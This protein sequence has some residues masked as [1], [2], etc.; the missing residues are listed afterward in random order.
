[1]ETLERVIYNS[2]IGRTKK[3]TREEIT[4]YVQEDGDMFISALFR[5]VHTIIEDYPK[6]KKLY[7]LDSCLSYIVDAAELSETVDPASIS[8]KIKKVDKKIDLIIDKKLNKRKKLIDELRTVKRKLSR[9]GE[10]VSEESTHRYDFIDYLIKEPRN[11]DF[12]EFTFK[13]IPV[14]M[15]AKDKAGITL[16]RNLNRSYMEC[17]QTGNTK[18]MSYY[19][20]L[21]LLMLSQESFRLTD[22]EKKDILKDIYDELER[23][24]RDKLDK[25]QNREKIKFLQSLKELIAP[26]KEKDYSLTDMAS[27]YEIP[28]GFPLEVIQSV[29]NYKRPINTSNYPDRRVFTDYVLSIDGPTTV[30]IDDA[31]SCRKMPNGHYFLGVHVASILGYY[32]YDSPIVENA[33]NRVK[34]IYLR[35]VLQRDQGMIPIFPE[36]FS[37]DIGALVEGRNR[38][39]RSYFFEIDQDGNVLNQRFMKTIINNKKRATYQEINRVLEKGTPIKE[40]DRTVNC[41]KEVS[42]ILSKKHHIDKLY[43]LIKEKTPDPSELK[44]K[45]TGSEDI[46][47]QCMLLTGNKV[48]EFFAEHN[49]PCLYRTHHGD[50]D[51]NNNLSNRVRE[52]IEKHGETEFEKMND[53]LNGLYPK[54]LYSSSGNHQ[55]LGFNNYCHCTS[56]LRRAADIVV[57]HALEVCYDKTPTEEEL[58]NLALDIR[59]KQDIINSKSDPIDWFVEDLQRGYQKVKSNKQR[60]R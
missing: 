52:M 25:K 9:V 21:I 8:K 33:F 22:E 7:N 47:Y 42:E 4:D 17:I 3:I 54:G 36:R 49:Y 12:I 18:E 32:D 13:K 59:K 45:K 30:E 60:G 55:G 40:L 20:S 1:M 24:S 27:K 48:A 10:K 46:V 57:E 38:L 23:M 14:V 37:T 5:V 26:K 15:Q 11:M 53:L 34:S 28:I 31:L 16:F 50:Q 19:K 56:G 43:E 6:S 44:V 41:L 51:L 29:D 2:V 58:R 35:N 39:A